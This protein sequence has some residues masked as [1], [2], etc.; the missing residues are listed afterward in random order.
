MVEENLAT[1][2]L[3]VIEKTRYGLKITS[4]QTDSDYM[5][6]RV[7]SESRIMGRLMQQWMKEE[8][9]TEMDGLNGRPLWIVI[10]T[11]VFDATGTIP[12]ALSPNLS[13]HE[14]RSGN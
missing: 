1:R 14:T 3:R 7:K 13:D 2:M 12:I 10:G 11:R 9:I 4:G 5:K 6:S 8:D